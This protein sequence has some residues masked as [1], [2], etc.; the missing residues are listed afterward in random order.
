MSLDN[1]LKYD[2]KYII[3][4]DFYNDLTT[5]NFHIIFKSYS[6]DYGSFDSDI[7]FLSLILIV[8]R[9]LKNQEI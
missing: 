5:E 4:E 9:M 6:D 1:I 8:Y 2:T 3:L 7:I